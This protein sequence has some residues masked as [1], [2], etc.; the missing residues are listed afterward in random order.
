MNEKIETISGEKTYNNKMFKYQD[1][2]YY[3]TTTR[4]NHKT[5]EENRT[6]RE[7]CDFNGCIYGVPKPISVNIPLKTDLFVFEMLNISKGQPDA[8]GKIMGIGMIKNKINF[9]KRHRIYSDQNYNRYC[10][11]GRRRVDRDEMSEAELTDLKVF[12]DMVF[13]GYAHL[14]RGQGITSIPQSKLIDK[15]NFIHKFLS[16]LFAM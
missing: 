2:T 15:K 1:T 5:F 6:Y 10:Y 4:F 11:I 13:R 9:K 12:E 16:K 7:K 14:K 3:V 8:P